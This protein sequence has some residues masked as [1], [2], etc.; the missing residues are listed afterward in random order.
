MLAARKPS[1]RP[2]AG[3][4]SCSYRLRIGSRARPHGL[5][6]TR[7]TAPVA[8]RTAR[9]KPRTCTICSRGLVAACG[10]PPIMWGTPSSMVLLGYANLTKIA[11]CRVLAGLRRLALSWTLPAS[12]WYVEPSRGLATPGA[13]AGGGLGTKANT[14]CGQMSLIT[15]LGS[16]LSCAARQ[17]RDQACGNDVG[18]RQRCRS[19]AAR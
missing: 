13:S 10:E 5:R 2:A 4:G 17:H 19:T 6:A 18:P 14:S 11:A 9:C 1:T 7:F 3:T 15:M 12:C 16:H 8:R